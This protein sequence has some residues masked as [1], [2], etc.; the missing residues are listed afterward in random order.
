MG[1]IQSIADLISM[2]RRR[3][4]MI[5]TILVV[6][7]LLSIYLAVSSPRIYQAT[8]VIQVDT[9]AIID[10][11]GDASLPAS[12]RVQLIEQRLMARENLREV[13]ARHDLFADA[14][15]LSE[16]EKIGAMRSSTRIESIS[17]PGVGTDAGGALAAIIIT[18]TAETAATAAA[19]ANDFADNVVNRD[20]Q[21]RQARI[22]ESRQYLTLEEQRLD[23]AINEH[24]NR[25][26]EFSAHNEASLPNTQ[27]YLQ[28][29]L[30]QIAESEATLDRDIMALQ[31]ERLALESTNNSE[32]VRP[33]AS[34]VQQI[35]SAEV[36]LAQARRTLAPE[37]PEI[38]RLELNLSR[39]LE[40]G[41]NTGAVATLR[42]TELIESQLKQLDGQKIAL[43]RRRLEIE[44]ARAL[45]P[46]V[47]RELETMTREQRRLQDRYAEVSRQLAQ[48][49]TQQLLIE[50]DQAEQF[51]L[52]ERALAPEYPASSNRKK[53]A[54][55]G[56]F[57]SIG[58]AFGVAFVLE[59][60]KP[61]LR[62]QTQFAR[63]TGTRPVISLPYRMTAQDFETRS[64]RRIYLVLICLIGLLGAAWLAGQ[65]PGLPGP[66]VVATPT[67][68]LG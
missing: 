46:Q 5:L 50:N 15:Q 55:L 40:G 48:V 61:V 4:P 39:L 67:D 30:T 56:M 43:E 36:E 25:M 17:A 63:V 26:V 16:S 52:L 6:G 24:D 37:H 8:A 58:L 1:P 60:M 27:E 47:S 7:G 35:R 12:R 21:N 57:V 41:A 13:I 33:A 18:S 64:R 51:I 2:I 66:G 19:L 59:M 68:G 23:T 11:T 65:L 29:E 9:P 32:D 38:A 44:R 53:S 20:I 31:R 14:P 45:A 34:L 22:I 42:Q 10:A 3:L 62:K 49:E 28:T 54:A